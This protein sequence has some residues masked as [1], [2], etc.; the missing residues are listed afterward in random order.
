MQNALTEARGEQLEIERIHRMLNYAWGE[1][2]LTANLLDYFGE[3]IADCGHCSSVGSAELDDFLHGLAS[4][5]MNRS[6]PAAS[7]MRG[8]RRVSDKKTI[9]GH[10][11]RV[12]ITVLGHAAVVT[13]SEPLHEAKK[14]CHKWSPYE[15]RIIRSTSSR[16]RR[17]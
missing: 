12:R 9:E 7:R 13:R 15:K 2:C 17:G 1:R 3:T 6:S 11:P 4:T 5:E 10:A 8:G 14:H 16:N